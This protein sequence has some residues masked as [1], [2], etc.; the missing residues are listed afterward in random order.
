M[1]RL[2][3]DVKK[4]WPLRFARLAQ[5]IQRVIGNGIGGEI[6]GKINMP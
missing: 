5:K 6:L 2:I 4:V 3:G 1:R